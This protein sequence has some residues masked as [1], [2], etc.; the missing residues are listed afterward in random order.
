MAHYN[1]THIRR[2]SFYAMP[3]SQWTLLSQPPFSIL[4]T[5]DAVDD[6][7]DA[8]ADIAEAALQTAVQYFNFPSWS[9][10]DDDSPPWQAPPDS[11]SMGKAYT[12]V[13]QLYRDWSAEG[14]SERD[15]CYAPVISALGT[16]FSSTP[17][18]KRGSIKVLVPG[19]GLGRLP[20]DICEA[21]FGVEGNEISYHMIVMSNFILNHT[22]PKKQYP[23]YPWAFG[24]SNHLRR[25]DQLH[26]VLIP[27]V[28]PGSALEKASKNME[29]HAFDRLSMTS[30]DFCVHYR[31]DDAKDEFDAVATVFFIDT[32]PNIIN[33]I[34]TVRNCLKTGGIWINLGPLLWHFEGNA[35]GVHTNG[36]GDEHGHSHDVR[37]GSMEPPQHMPPSAVPLSAVVDEASLQF[38]AGSDGGADKTA[39]LGIA[40]SGSV[41]LTDEEVRA[42]LEKFGFK[43]ER[44]ELAAETG[45]IQNPNS[46]LQSVYRPSFWIAR[47][48]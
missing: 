42:L 43:V 25:A 29:V 23:L 11:T 46:M 18:P 9:P 12:T 37:D 48:L 39:N 35:P 14:K 27:D 38:S 20:F 21:G 34:E 30:A 15:A 16:E 31:R 45:Y 33:Y 3:S 19:A 32:A 5:F 8:N 40:E 41:E 1:I 7:I 6:A 28:H 44:H 24:F 22:R 2:Q 13:R 26:R 4:S 47:K 36:H 10:Q 17:A